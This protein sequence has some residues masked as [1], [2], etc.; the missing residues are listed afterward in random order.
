M[1]LFEHHWHVLQAVL[2]WHVGQSEHALLL[3][4]IVTVALCLL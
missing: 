3:L 1:I 4:I 2:N